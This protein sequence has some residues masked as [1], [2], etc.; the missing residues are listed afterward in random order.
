M[1]PKPKVS[2]TWVIVH[3]TLV[4]LTHSFFSAAVIMANPPAAAICSFS[5]SSPQ[6]SMR[7]FSLSL[8]SS[9]YRSWTCQDKIKHFSLFSEVP[10]LWQQVSYRIDVWSVNLPNFLP[11]L[12]TA[13]KIAHA[14]C[15][16]LSDLLV[17]LKHVVLNL[18]KGLLLQD[19]DS[20]TRTKEEIVISNKDYI[21]GFVMYNVMYSTHRSLSFSAAKLVR[22][23]NDS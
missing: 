17:L 10:A 2:F 6:S 15:S 23:T 13:H 7:S 11:H 16:G 21:T 5:S 12:F 14:L 20:E 22:L 3:T 8:P 1:S 18:W 4:I 19:F 9:R